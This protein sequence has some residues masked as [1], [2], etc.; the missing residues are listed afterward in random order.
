MGIIPVRLHKPT[1]GLIPTKPFIDDGETIEPSVSVPIA[2]AHKLADAA[3]PEPALDPLGLRSRP[4]GHLVC[5]P[6]LRQA[7][8]ECV[9]RKFA[10]SLRLVLPSKT[11]PA[12][13]SFLMIKASS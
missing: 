8:V 4:H 11:A 12:S 5:P 13:R 3:D 1:V 6:L 10:H 9:E 2:M 7:L